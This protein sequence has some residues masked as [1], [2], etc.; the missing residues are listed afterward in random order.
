MDNEHKP[1]NLWAEPEEPRD[2]GLCKLE[3]A[4]LTEELLKDCYE[5]LTAPIHYIHI[6]VEIPIYWRTNATCTNS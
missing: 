1:I 5:L 2:L 4:I 3:S 6:T